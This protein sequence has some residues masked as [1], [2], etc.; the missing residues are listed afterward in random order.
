MGTSG[1]LLSIHG[2][3]A[4]MLPDQK[5]KRPLLL[6]PIITILVFSFLI[7]ISGRFGYSL[8]NV[9]GLDRINFPPPHCAGF[10]VMCC[11]SLRMGAENLRSSSLRWL[12]IPPVFLFIFGAITAGV[13]WPIFKNALSSALVDSTYFR[14]SLALGILPSALVMITWVTVVLISARRKTEQMGLAWSTAVVAAGELIFFVRLGFGINDELLRLMILAIVCFAAIAMMWRRIFIAAALMVIAVISFISILVQADYRLAPVEDPYA[15]PPKHIVFLQ[16]VAGV[17]E[18]NPRILS[19]QGIMIPN[20]GNAFG[21]SELTSLN[22]L[23]VDRTAKIIFNL[24]SMKE[25][26]YTTPNA[27]PASLRTQLIHLG[28]IILPT[29]RFTMLLQLNTWLIRQ[30]GH[31]RR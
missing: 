19:S 28:M 23:Q 2:L 5:A 17:E 25:L 22:P 26:D 27:W 31:Y 13:T 29:D 24:L 9:P 3:T 10:I 1:L 11:L 20:V 8:W 16:S 4:F 15:I 14:G 7:I 30:P 21:L 18:G 6:F 12:I